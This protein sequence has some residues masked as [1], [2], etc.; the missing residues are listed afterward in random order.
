MNVKEEDENRDLEQAN[1]NTFLY[2]LLEVNQEL[3][4]LE[5]E[6]IEMKNSAFMQD[7]GLA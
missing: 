2:K 6:G 5:Y 3:F 7:I 1:Y 4:K